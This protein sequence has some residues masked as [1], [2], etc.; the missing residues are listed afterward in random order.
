[1]LFGMFLPAQ[2]YIIA[3]TI[4]TVSYALSTIDKSN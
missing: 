1:M 3:K 4:L 2:A